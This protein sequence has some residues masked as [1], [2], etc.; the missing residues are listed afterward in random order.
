MHYDAV[1]CTVYSATEPTSC[2]RGNAELTCQA[3]R[4][5][6]GCVGWHGCLRV[7]RIHPMRLKQTGHSCRRASPKGSHRG[8]PTTDCP[9]VRKDTQQSCDG[10]PLRCEWLTAF[11]LLRVCFSHSAAHSTARCRPLRSERR[12]RESRTVT[13]SR[14]ANQGSSCGGPRARPGATRGTRGG[15]G[16]PNQR[17]SAHATALQD[18]RR[19]WLCVPCG[20]Q[21]RRLPVLSLACVSFGHQRAG[22]MPD[23]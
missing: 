12:P 3:L 2:A 9:G 11:R 7:T 17:A 19:M 13:G 10:T 20:I 22:S 15:H 8:A 14:G 16:P 6:C 1:H 5:E 4:S 21:R 23:N 18:R